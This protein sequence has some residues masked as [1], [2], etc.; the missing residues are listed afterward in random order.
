[1]AAAAALLL[2]I[3]FLRESRARLIEETLEAAD[4]QVL[5]EELQAERARSRELEGDLSR[6]NEPV[7]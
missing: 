6:Q 2:L 5:S 7:H 4:V 3:Y 1:M